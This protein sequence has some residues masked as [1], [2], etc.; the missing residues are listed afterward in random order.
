MKLK[1]FLTKNNI[2]L[3]PQALKLCKFAEIRLKN[4]VDPIH[5]IKHIERM[6]GNLDYLI[7]K[8]KQILNKLNMEVMV[9]SL[10]WHDIWNSHQKVVGFFNLLS[11][12]IIEGLKSAG[13]FW[14]YALR[15]KLDK[16]LALNVYYAIRKHSSFQLMPLFTLESK[17]LVDLDKIE[18]WNSFRLFKDKTIYVA[19]KSFY[20][21]YVVRF[22]YYYSYK[23]GLYSNV[24][25]KRFE[26]HAKRFWKYNGLI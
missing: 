22:Y 15:T 17:V 16:K 11:N 19:N 3:S 21:K 23:M 18:L 7:R 13:I 12:Q 8:Q 10:L 14:K 20:Q 2:K 6:L 4:S 5:D 1:T 25:N 26:S 24:L 9:L